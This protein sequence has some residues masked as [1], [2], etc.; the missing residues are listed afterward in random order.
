MVM[1]PFSNISG[2][3]LGQPMFKLLHE[4]QGL[5]RRGKRILHFEIGDTNFRSPSQAVEAAK[6]ALDADQTHYTS[7]FGQMEFLE[8]IA[9]VSEKNLGFRPTM[10]QT[11][12]CPANALID[13]VVRCVVN[14]GEEV[15]YPDPGFPTY[16]SVI[17]YNGMIPVGVPL[18]AENQFR[19]NPKDVQSRI[20]EKTRLII[21]NSPQNPTGAV[22]TREE[23]MGMA[24]IAKE[25]GVYLLSDEVYSRIIFEGRHHSPSMADQC[26]ERTIVLG[27]LSKLY[28]M[29]GWRLGY[30]IGPEPLIEKLGLLLQTILSCLPPFTQLGGRAAL[31]FGERLLEER[32]AIFRKRRDR[33]VKGL[34]ALA[35]VSCIKPD[36][37]ICL[38]MDI[39]NTEIS[40]Q[41]YS[42]R[43]LREVGVCVLP[44]RCFGKFGQKYVRLCF[45]AASTEIIDEALEYMR[46]FHE[47]RL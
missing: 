27:S 40:D 42:A 32:V 34:N 1:K 30:V 12:A 28:S 33:L 15:I 35:G 2:R 19:M 36:G 21:M 44:G 4:A 47:K 13:F 11:L 24:D 10:A 17:N 16:F 18:K 46:F 3:L 20:S 39:R 31:L 14:P 29:S 6:K 23:V 37:S 45:G 5:E 22:M 25:H 9:E 26:R 43:L 7:S 8:A 38:L 41:T